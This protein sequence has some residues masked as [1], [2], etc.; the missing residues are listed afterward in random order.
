MCFGDIDRKMSW[1]RSS[2][3]DLAVDLVAQSDEVELHPLV[4]PF[5]RQWVVFDLAGLRIEGSS[6]PWYMVSNQN[7]PW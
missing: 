3:P 7:L 1:C 6:E 2:C 5:R 4:V